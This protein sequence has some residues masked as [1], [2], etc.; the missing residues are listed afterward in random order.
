MLRLL[1]L[2]LDS[3]LLQYNKSLEYGDA[4]LYKHSTLTG[5]MLQTSKTALLA[6][7]IAAPSIF[8][9]FLPAPGQG[10]DRETMEEGYLILHGLGVMR[11]LSTDKD[12]YKIQSTFRFNK[13]IGYLYTA[14]LLVETGLLLLESSSSKQGGVMTP[15]VAFGS[16]LTQRIVKELDASFEIQE[17]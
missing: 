7:A 5:W 15:A 9:R 12:E 14:A 17:M 16:R 2:S 4:Q 6:A 8:G 13:D 11:K 3:A 1:Y 10:P